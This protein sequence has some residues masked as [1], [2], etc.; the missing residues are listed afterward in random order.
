[1]VGRCGNHICCGSTIDWNIAV[2]CARW[3]KLGQQRW[4]PWGRVKSANRNASPL[5]YINDKEGGKN[6]CSL[7]PSRCSLVTE[8]RSLLVG[9]VARSPCAPRALWVR[10]RLAIGTSHPELAE[11]IARRYSPSRQSSI[12]PPSPS[13]PQSRHPR[14]KSHSHEIRHW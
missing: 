6:L 5:D 9:V 2:C 8:S 14:C 13:L 3:A 7:S 4:K 1:M 12:L 10:V 11:I